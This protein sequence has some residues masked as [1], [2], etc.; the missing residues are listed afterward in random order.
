MR[1]LHIISGTNQGGAE[2]MLQDICATER[3]NEHSVISLT[4]I[5]PVGHA[6]AARGTPITSMNMRAAKPQALIQLGAAIRAA[7]A[8]IVQCWLYHGNVIGGSIARC[9]APRARILWSIHQTNVHAGVFKATTVALVKVGAPLSYWVPDRILY[10]AESARIAH[11]ELGYAPRRGV[12]QPNGFDTEAFRPNQ[13]ARNRVRVKLAI[14]EDA[15]TVGFFARYSE[16]KDFPNCLRALAAL[17]R[18]HPTVIAVMAGRDVE[19]SNVRLAREIAQ[20]SLRPENVR[21]LGF[22]ERT[23]EVMSAMD[24]VALSSRVEAFPLVLGEALACGIPVVS[25]R[26]GDAATIVG[27]DGVVVPPGDAEALCSG[28]SALLSLPKSERQAIGLRGRQRIID[29]YDL[30]IV[31]RSYAEIYESLTRGQ[32]EL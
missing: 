1:V 24:I 16:Q 17:V 28:M 31:S 4:S 19:V 27:R 12:V 3:S 22:V 2:R 25:T 20:C 14:P 5:G 18:K 7:R 23:A 8:D 11:E 32:S 21:L 15:P 10:C 30:A 6:I 29:L 26:V 9:V 13:E